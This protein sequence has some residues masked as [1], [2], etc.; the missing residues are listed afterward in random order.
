MAYYTAGTFTKN[1]LAR[2]ESVEAELATIVSAF[3]KVPEQLSLEQDRA[4]YAA[5]TGSAN[6]YVIALPA[7]LAAYTTGLAVRVKIANL[8]TGAST[9]NIDSLGVK[10]ITRFNGDA[11]EAGDLAAGAVIELYYD[12]TNFQTAGGA[13]T[14]TNAVIGPASAT[15]NAVMRFNGTT[16][17]L[18]QDTALVVISDTPTMAI[19]VAS[20]DG[21]LHVHT[22]TAGSVTATSVADDLIVENSTDAGISVLCP[23]AD[24]GYLMFGSPTDATG[25]SVRW[26]FSNTL[27]TVGT[28]TA[29]GIIAFRSG[30][31]QEAMRIDAAGE[32]G[33]G[34]TSP[35]GTLHVHTA[36][37]GSVTANG[38]AND[39]VVENSGNGGISI[40]TPDASSGQ[41]RFGSPAD[42]VGASIIYQ[43]STALM[44]IGT[45]LASGQIRFDTA[46]TSEAMRIDANGNLGIGIATPDGTL[47][48][49]TATAGSVAAWTQADDLVVE[50]SAHGGIT[51]LVP[52]ASNA[53][54]IFGSNSDNI[55]AHITYKQSNTQMTIGTSIASGH[56]IF[57]VADGAEAMRIFSNGDIRL[58]AGTSALATNSTG[59]FPG[60]PTM[61]GD[62][63]ATPTNES[64]GFASFCYDTTN[65][66]FKVWNPIS[67]DWRVVAMAA[68]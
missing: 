22:A 67:N 59:G 65:N 3:N 24:V 12:G 39:L 19:G 36:T 41:I 58:S 61:A 29:S 63:S 23:N 25:A 64:S 21:T 55:G 6:A 50:N 37:A 57:D 48:V 54:L 32:V 43:Q 45:N 27:M 60:M 35:D 15:D 56:I 20:P 18:A 5:D 14:V 40:L 38:N 30:N 68:Q 7:T 1:T 46:D 52:D 4:A 51:I 42:N 33:I 2:A 53:N 62:A 44:T 31:F 10:T 66:E 34:T 28:Q 47:H 9:L 49:H 26:D 13:A 17:K 11:L 8:N 16:G